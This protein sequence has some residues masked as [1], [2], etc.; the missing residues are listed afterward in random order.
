MKKR[1]IAILLMLALT[2]GMLAACSGK[3]A[4]EIA[5]PVTLTYLTWNYADRPESTDFW[6]K[7]CKEKFNI[8]I[9]MQNSPT[10]NYAAALK[11]RMSGNDMPD[12]VMTHGIYP[13]YSSVDA[14]FTAET[15][16]DLSQLENIQNFDPSAL[17]G[18]TIDGKIFYVPISA[19]TAGVLYN[20][21]VF[22]DNGLKIPTNYDELIAVMETLKGNGIAPLA[23]SFGEAWTCQ[24]I[25]IIAM[26]A[27]VTAQDPDM[28]IK[29][30][31]SGNNT[32]SM[33]YASMG[34]A[35]VKA[36]GLGKKWVDAG[37]FTNDPAGS[38]A[39][40]ACQML[41][42]GKAAMFISGDW[43]YA[44]AAGVSEDPENI[45]FFALPLNNSGDPIVMPSKA[46]EGMCINANSENIEAAKI[47]M[48]YYLS[49]EIQQ[50]VINET[51]LT[52]TNKNCTASGIFSNEV[53]SALQNANSMPKGWL[54]GTAYWMPRN[55]SFN[56][57]I[58]TQSVLCGI[59]TAEEFLADLDACIAEVTAQ[60]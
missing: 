33:T 36:I 42:T 35:A 47:A 18:V 21:Q 19:M 29:V 57:E 60:N 9:E 38:D 45:G 12:L 43:E 46:D 13:D 4:A 25:P 1:L 22:A 17:G 5:E 37:Y 39:S 58:E 53:A 51:G 23:G 31:N 34:D 14:K 54:G 44:A 6:I 20:K 2:V 49:D 7:G 27:Y 52:S 8:T 55:A 3:K 40:A 28:G 50:V 11:T 24:I 48:N 26:D 30:Y 59:K 32:S 15:F 16:L 41:A 10:E 56:L